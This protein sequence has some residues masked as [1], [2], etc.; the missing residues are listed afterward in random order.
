MFLQSPQTYLSVADF[1]AWP[2]DRDISSYTDSQLEDIL[3][4]AS[5]TADSIMGRSYLPQEVT[6]Y[7]EG[8]GTSKLSLDILGPI[9][10]V[11]NVELVLP[12]H[13]PF[14]LPLSQLLIDYQRGTIRS[15]SPLVW[16]TFGVSTVFPRN[17][18]PIAVTYAYGKGY[19]VPA[20]SFSLSTGPQ[21]GGLTPGAQYDVAVSTRTMSGESLPAQTQTFTADANGSINVAISPQPGAYVY[22]VYAAAHGAA[23]GL[24]AESPATN[25]GTATMTVAIT[26][27]TAPTN[28][29]A[30]PVPTMDT[31]AWPLEKA[32]VEATRI[33]ALSIIDEQ[34]NLA[35]RGV[36]MQDDGRQRISWRGTD[37]NSAKGVPGPVQMA[38]TLLSPFKFCGIF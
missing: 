4:S 12:G 38:D 24:V 35:N 31:S 11:K 28:L 16:Q 15:Y 37:G 5:A 7:F 32:F 21:G 18:I 19:P 34:N 1:K 2:N 9:I 17:N 3:V 30:L 33:L 10:Y 26:S 6:E 36:Y 8:D 13:A 25:Y 27:L 22:R 20:P 23:L 29:G 14:E